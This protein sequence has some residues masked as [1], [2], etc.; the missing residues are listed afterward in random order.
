VSDVSRPTPAPIT[1]EE[2]HAQSGEV[3]SFKTETG[4]PAECPEGRA[5]IGTVRSGTDSS[6]C[7]AAA[8]GAA[9]PPQGQ[10]SAKRA[11]CALG[12]DQTCNEDPK[13]SAIWGHCTELGVCECK[14]GFALTPM[15]RCRPQ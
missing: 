7:C 13:T 15:G 8:G 6:A 12:T 3:L 1:E 5:R 4:S 9:A 14:P 10:V 11:P 2:C